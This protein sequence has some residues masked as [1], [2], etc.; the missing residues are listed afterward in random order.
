MTTSFNPQFPS[1]DQLRLRAPKPRRRP[2]EPHEWDL[3]NRFEKYRHASQRF[4]DSVRRGYTPT[5]PSGP[6]GLMYPLGVAY[7]LEGLA[8]YFEALQ[9]QQEAAGNAHGARFYKVIHAV[10][11]AGRDPLTNPWLFDIG[12]KKRTIQKYCSLYKNNGPIPGT[13]RRGRRSQFPECAPIVRAILAENTHA[14]LAE[15]RAKLDEAGH[16]IS[17]A[18]LSSWRRNVRA[19]V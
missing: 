3:E 2:Q 6:S 18:T 5:V 10:Y 12:L 16:S 1:V 13:K 14:T 11:L 15:I 17:I 19:E 7:T 8:A 4:D 9:R